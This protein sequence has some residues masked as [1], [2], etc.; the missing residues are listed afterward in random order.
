VE[1][2]VTPADK[3]KVDRAQARI[4][5]YVE[6]VKKLPLSLAGPKLQAALTRTRAQ[7]DKEL[8]PL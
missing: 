2:T 8:P 5:R 1:R 6:L 4:V 7:V 3:A